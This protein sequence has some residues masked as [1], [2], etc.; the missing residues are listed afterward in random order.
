MNLSQ[1]NKNTNVNVYG[2]EYTP[3]LGGM[4]IVLYLEDTNDS[5]YRL[6]KNS[7]IKFKVFNLS[8]N[9]H[10]QLSFSGFGWQYQSGWSGRDSGGRLDTWAINPIFNFS[11]EVT[12]YLIYCKEQYFTNNDNNGRTR[13]YL[14]DLKKFDNS[15]TA[16]NNCETIQVRW[17]GAKYSDGK[18]DGNKKIILSLT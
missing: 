4:L 18:Y 16:K 5:E 9:N 13:F 8:N 3:Y 12:K 14:L 7:Q 6:V 10:P 15:S 17:E 2:V 1:N 11:G